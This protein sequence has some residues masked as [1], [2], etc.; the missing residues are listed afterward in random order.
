M[1]DAGKLLDIVAKLARRGD[2]TLLTLTDGT[3]R[4]GLLDPNDGVM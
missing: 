2:D 3:Y 1:Q 4:L